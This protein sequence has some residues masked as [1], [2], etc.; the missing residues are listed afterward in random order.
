M[1]YRMKLELTSEVKRTIQTGAALLNGSSKRL[2]W[3]PWFPNWGV[4]DNVWHQKS[5][6][7]IVT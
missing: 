6:A 4:A 7:G 1:L 2:L 5:L 3:L